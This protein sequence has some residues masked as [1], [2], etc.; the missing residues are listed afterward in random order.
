M[1][2][3]TLSN[4]NQNKSD[5]PNSILTKILKLLNKDLTDQLV[6]LFNQSLPSHLEYFL[7]C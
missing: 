7:H 4:L 2:F 3:P 1:T 5:R 6:I